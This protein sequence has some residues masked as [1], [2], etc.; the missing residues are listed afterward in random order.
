MGKL[1]QMTEHILAI[2]TLNLLMGSTLDLLIRIF[3]FSSFFFGSQGN[4]IFDNTKYFTDFP[5]FF[6]GGIRR[7][8]A[9]NSW[10]P[11]NT[12][13]SIPKLRT[14]GGFSTDASGYAN[15]YFIS[16]GSYLRCKQMQLGYTIPAKTLSKFGIDRLRVYIQSANLF[17]ITKYKGLDPELQSQPDSNGRINNTSF[18]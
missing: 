9:I 16:K 8:V 12:N 2:Q 4:D 3:D 14:S 1:M 7:E 6:K 17:T 10:T 18:E 11:N 15:S 13:T 5:D